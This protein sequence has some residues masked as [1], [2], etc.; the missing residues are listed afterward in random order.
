M[1][2]VWKHPESVYWFARFRDE[3]GVK[4]NRSTKQRDRKKAAEV[5]RTLEHAANLARQGNLTQ[6]R[7]RA[8]LSEILE[9]TSDSTESIRSETV[10]TFFARHAE[11]LE[12]LSL[13]HI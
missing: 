1:A 8:L 5:A 11:S 7:A 4:V 9:R 12:E 10:E 6:E 2:F 3:R 13:I